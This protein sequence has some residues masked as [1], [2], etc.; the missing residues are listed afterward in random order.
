M[1]PLFTDTHAHLADPQLLSDVDGVI[2]RALAD[3]VERIL[4]VG[5][6]LE[7]SRVCVD[8]ASRFD[9]VYAAIGIH[10]HESESF[11][12]ASIQALRLLADQPKVVAIGETGLDFYRET[13]SADVQRQ[14]FAAQVSLAAE[15]GLPVVV[16]NRGADDDVM[17]ILTS[18]ERPGE[19]STRGGVL[20]CFTGDVE[21]ARR[22]HAAGFWISFAGNLTYG[23]SGDLR[24]VA[25]EL[26]LDWLL[27][28]TDSP[29]LSPEPRRGKTNS[30]SNVRYV[31]RALAEISDTS[32][33]DV[34]A[35][36]RLNAQDLLG[37]SLS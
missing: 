14:A 3:G 15:I 5:T 22:A 6:T 36:V 12:V 16:H 17:A 4:A 34:A 9:A 24:A 35:T 29:Y 30:P 13:A 28:E 21:L 10:P 33:S 8:L 18:V 19:Q 11:D 25:R 32:D 27:T 23:R 26:P 1:S 37:W 7:S 2:A 31:V 20:H